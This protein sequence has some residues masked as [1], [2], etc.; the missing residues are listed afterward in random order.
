MSL[1]SQ[2][3]QKR[4]I[5]WDG[6]SIFIYFFH[7]FSMMYVLCTC[8]F[9]TIDVYSIS[10]HL[11]SV[12]DTQA[13]FEICIDSESDDGSEDTGGS[14]NEEENEPENLSGEHDDGTLL[15]RVSF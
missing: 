10:V 6:G 13:S 9:H 1:I 2:Y 14:E 8:H 15:C 5:F 12:T 3:F 11:L 4:L 7:F